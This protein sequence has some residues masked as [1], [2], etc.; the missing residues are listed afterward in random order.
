[1]LSSCV[2]PSVCLSVT[3]WYCLISAKHRITQTTKTIFFLMPKILAKFEPGHL[4][5]GA[6]CRRSRLKSATFDT[7]KR[8]KID[9]N[10]LLNSNR[11]SFALYRTL[12]LSMT[13]G[14]PNLSKPPFFYI[15][16][17][18]LHLPMGECR[19]FKFVGQVDHIKFQQ[20]E[21]KRK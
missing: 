1:M 15:L 17:C 18:L 14:N 7:R 5:R 12:M 16:R 20:H 19:D 3:R 6:K 8:Y 2:R 21:T 13:V 10:F 11:K 9:A 4:Q